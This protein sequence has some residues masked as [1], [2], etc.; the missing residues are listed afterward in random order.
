[1]TMTHKELYLEQTGTRL[2]MHPKKFA[3]WLFIVSIIMFFAAFTSAYLV[4]ASEGQLLNMKLPSLFTISTLVIILSSVSMQWAY[5]SA[6]RNEIKS[7]KGMLI[8]T[9]ILGIIFLVNQFAGWGQLVDQNIYFAGSNSLASF[10]YVLT[11]LHGLHLLGGII[12]LFITT[13]AALKYKVHSKNIILIQ[14]CATY[15]HFLGGLWIYLFLFL[16]VNL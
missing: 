10:I 9:S 8:A 14:M 13:I 15:W 6:K 4:K 5:V 1:M 11:G 16:N 2:V 3:L 7:I 12:F